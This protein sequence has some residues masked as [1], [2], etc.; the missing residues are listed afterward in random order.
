MLFWK[1]AVILEIMR[2]FKLFIAILTGSLSMHAGLRLPAIMSDHIVLQH[3]TA[4]N[5][6]GWSDRPGEVTVTTSWGEKATAKPDAETGRWQ[7]AVKTPAASYTPYSITIT[8]GDETLT[9]NDV[10]AGEVWMASGQSNM[11]M[12]LRGFGFQP[13]E[14]AG[15]A[16]AYSGDYPGVRMH[17]VTRTNSYTPC[18]D[19]KGTGWLVSSPENAAEFSATA[20]FYA[21]ALNRL[22]KVPVGMLVCSYGGSKVE[23]WLPNEI[24]SQYPDYD[25]EKERND[26]K[27]NN[28]ERVTIMYNAMLLPIKSYTVKGFIWNQGEANVWKHDTYAERLKTMVEL[29]RDLWGN[30]SLPFYQVEIPGWHYSNPDGDA[31]AK[32]REAQHEAA[33]IIDRCGIIS[34]T[35][36]VYPHEVHVI[37]ASQK[38]PIGERLAWLAASDTYG[39]KG[40]PVTY[41]TFKSVEYQGDKA[42]LSFNAM[43][44]GFSPHIDIPGFEVA[45]EDMVFHPATAWEDGNTYVITVSSPEVKEVKA[46][47]YAFKNFS[48]GQLHDM[49]GLP[50]VPFRTDKD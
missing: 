32:L 38:K 9:L 28:W 31:A 4:A 44:G 14:G 2:I 36:L 29:W 22:L 48:P 20:Y 16:V 46:V 1:N 24:V 5:L 43:L 41:P 37:H 19:V 23:G 34:T 30:D 13:I 11:D 10:L 25:I 33:R 7:V 18:D 8:Q 21:M 15:E 35:D 50:L 12:P 26:P 6:W 40:L 17:T 3:S 47:R 45:G 39:I 27:V 49:M 42:L